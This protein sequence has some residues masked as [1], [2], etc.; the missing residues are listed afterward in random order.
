MGKTLKVRLEIPLRVICI[1][2]VFKARGL[3]TSLRESVKIEEKSR[4]EPRAFQGLQV[5]DEEDLAE[6]TE[7]RRPVKEEEA[8]TFDL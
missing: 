5:R 7:P 6:E 2:I 1:L 3:M 4:A 8:L